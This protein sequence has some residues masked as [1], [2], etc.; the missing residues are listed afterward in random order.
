MA[1]RLGRFRGNGPHA[2]LARRRVAAV[3]RCRDGL[4]DRRHGRLTASESIGRDRTLPAAT[5]FTDVSSADLRSSRWGEPHP[6]PLFR[7]CGARSPLTGHFKGRRRVAAPLHAS[8]GLS[9]AASGPLD[10]L[11]RSRDSFPVDRRSRGTARNRPLRPLKAARGHPSIP[12]AQKMPQT[13]SEGFSAH[14]CVQDR[15]P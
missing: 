7:C 8:S 4:P 12:R 11:S 5:P 6:T 10:L 1:A 14:L 2:G 15:V 9:D 3:V 13:A